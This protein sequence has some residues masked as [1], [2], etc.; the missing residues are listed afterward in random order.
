MAFVIPSVNIPHLPKFVR[1]KQVVDSFEVSFGKNYIDKYE[2]VERTNGKTGQKF[3]MVFIHFKKLQEDPGNEQLT[4]F[5][6]LMNTGK[7]AM[8]YYGTYINQATGELFYFKTRAYKPRTAVNNSG[9]K[10]GMM[11]SEDVVA[12]K[13]TTR[14]ER[15]KASKAAAEEDEEIDD[16]TNTESEAEEEE[17]DEEN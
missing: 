1:E 2:S 9:V 4:E 17:I 14:P 10:K 3:Q 8:F 6:R 7:M 12:L 5:I 15:K 11:T 13:K 16:E